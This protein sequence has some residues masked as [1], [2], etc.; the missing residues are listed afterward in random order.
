MSW[1]QHC[2][3]SFNSH[4]NVLLLLWHN[5]FLNWHIATA[6]VF[7]VTLNVLL[8]TIVLIHFLSLS[9][10]VPCSH[11][12]KRE[13]IVIRCIRKWKV[14]F[15][16]CPSL[17]TS[18]RPLINANISRQNYSDIIIDMISF[19]VSMSQSS[20]DSS[21][22]RQ[23]CTFIE[24]QPTFIEPQ[25]TLIEHQPPFTEPALSFIEPQPTIKSQIF[26]CK[27]HFHLP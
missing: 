8:A 17:S 2:T 14:F 22:I 24:P 26:Q 10:S 3:R 23:P 16:L 9:I 19:T 4:W 21:S 11:D 7:Y 20:Q 25:P 27:K 15:M 5:L 18:N 1:R 12:W 13:A 6:M